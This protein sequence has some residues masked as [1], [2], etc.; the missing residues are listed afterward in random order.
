MQIAD[1]DAELAKAGANVTGRWSAARFLA[2]RYPLGAIGAAIM[3]M[4]VF[5]AL[6]AELIT[7]YDPLATDAAL[8]LA[9]PGAAHWMGA[10]NFGRDV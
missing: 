4:F 6:F 1:Y 7:F 5:A 3:G 8:S 10:D 9:P 2:R